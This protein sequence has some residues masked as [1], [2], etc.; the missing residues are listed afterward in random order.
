LTN[1]NKYWKQ[2][3]RVLSDYKESEESYLDD[4][5]YNN[6]ID[7]EEMIEKFREERT[8]QKIRWQSS[9]FRDQHCANWIGEV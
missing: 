9:L 7:E 4:N 3:S 1:F 5:G 6:Y 2:S 8:Y